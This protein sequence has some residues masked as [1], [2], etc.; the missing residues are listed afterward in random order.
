MKT[1]ILLADGFE[2]CEALITVD[3]FRRAK[4]EIDLVSIDTLHVTSAQKVEVVCDKVL[5]EV[6]LNA[7]ECLILPGGLPGTHNLEHCED[8]VKA[9]SLHASMGKL[10]CAI[11]AAPSI[12]GHLGLLEGKQ[13]TC[14]PGWED[15]GYLG[16]YTKADCVKDG[17]VITG[18]GMGCTIAFACCILEE[19]IGVEKV[20]ELK[21]G[22]QFE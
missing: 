17:N 22:I 20:L 3:L 11:C 13:Y 7:Y 9:V 10:V 6:D 14:Y 21:R 18:R 4:V 2:L 12:L 5:Q 1:A 16:T 19:I 15:E 8:V